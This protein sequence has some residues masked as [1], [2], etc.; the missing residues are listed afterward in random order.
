MKTDGAKYR[1]RSS[2][3]AAGQRANRAMQ[4]IWRWLIKWS[5]M[6]ESGGADVRGVFSSFRSVRGAVKVAVAPILGTQRSVLT[7]CSL[8]RRKSGGPGGM[9]SS[10]GDSLV[11]V[12]GAGSDSQVRKRGR[13]PQPLPK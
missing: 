4:C 13:Q 2:K 5:W 12:I 7:V 3:F 10:A 9:A 11:A 1:A 8:P 6:S